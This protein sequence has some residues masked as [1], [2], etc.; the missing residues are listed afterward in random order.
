[1]FK[2]SVHFASLVISQI[3]RVV[4]SVTTLKIDPKAVCNAINMNAE[5]SVLR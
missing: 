5:I 3:Y 2:D 1:M 4:V